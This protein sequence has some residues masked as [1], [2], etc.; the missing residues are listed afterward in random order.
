[1][2]EPLEFTAEERAEDAAF[3]RTYGPWD[4]LDVEGARELLDGFERPW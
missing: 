2:R 4:P 3:Y 1:M